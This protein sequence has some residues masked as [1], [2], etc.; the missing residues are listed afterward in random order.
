MI[1]SKKTR[2]DAAMNDDPEPGTPPFLS[3][4]ES[5]DLLRLQKGTLPRW[6]SEGR[7][8]AWSYLGRRVVYRREDLLAFVAANRVATSEQS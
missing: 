8:P 4:P 3:C 1:N 7:G 2:Q 5:H 6:R